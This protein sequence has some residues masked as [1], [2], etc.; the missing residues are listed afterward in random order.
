MPLRLLVHG[1]WA[2]A[3]VVLRRSR[4][5]RL[6]P[7]WPFRFE[8]IVELMRVH[9]KWL[10]KLEPEALRRAANDLAQ[11][12]PPNITLHLESIAGVPCTWFTR[13]DAAGEMLVFVH[14][15]AFVFGSAQQAKGN[16]AQLALR[17]RRR[18]VAPDYRLA[19]EQ[20]WP[21]APDD[22]A[23]VYRALLDRG[24]SP[25][26]IG[27][28]GES[29]GAGVALSALQRLRDARIPL[30]SSCVLLSPAVDLCADSPSWASNRGVDY[31]DPSYILVWNRMYAGTHAL[32]DPNVSPLRADCSGLP[33]LLVVA[34]TAELLVDDALAL[35]AKARAAGVPT[36]L[37]LGED[38]VHAYPA[39]GPLAPHA[40]A[41]W[42]AI[43]R[44][45]RVA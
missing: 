45:L 3:V 30:P 16:I 22:L 38:M 35:A 41:A 40:E 26:S 34:G 29:A 23:L 17:T 19:P 2:L 36:D 5:K 31:G 42:Q 11:P 20:P 12:L 21:A 1:L 28:V 4:G 18:V 37:V 14:G 9:S 43:E 13:P 7:S 10:A 8:V 33:R 15:G 27:V 39:F 24:L 32:T 25:Q 44:F 6:R